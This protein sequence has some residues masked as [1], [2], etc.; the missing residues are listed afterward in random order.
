MYTPAQYAASGNPTANVILNANT[1]SFGSPSHV[2]FDKAGNLWV[3]DEDI[4]NGNGGNGEVFK[5]T[6]S[7]ITNLSAGTNSIDP[8]SGIAYQGFVHLE[9]LAFDKKGNM[10]L[11]DEDAVKV[12]KFAA[13]QLSG[14]GLS[15]NLIPDVVLGAVSESGPC[16]QSL[17]NPYGLALDNNGN[18]YVSNTNLL[19]SGCFGSLA[20]FSAKSITAS[21][22]PTP[23]VFITQ[24]AQ[25]ENINDPNSLTFGPT[26]P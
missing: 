6:K 24:D 10:W 11:A 18:L 7:Q 8:V 17:D 15:Q 1:F 4:S 14:T 2:T 12:Y 19:T 26:I 5:Y 23:K 16:P 3:V 22:T 21:G 20:E 9:D 13:K 25:G